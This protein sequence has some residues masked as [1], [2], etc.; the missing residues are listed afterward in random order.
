SCTLPA[1][2]RLSPLSL[3][4]ALPILATGSQLLV[5][6]GDHLG[7]CLVEALEVFSQSLVRV[8]TLRQL[9]DLVPDPV[10]DRVGAVFDLH[11]RLKR[12]LLTVQFLTRRLQ[13]LEGIHETVDIPEGLL[14]FTTEATASR[15]VLQR[16]G[17]LVDI[18]GRPL[19]PVCDRVDTPRNGG[20][21]QSTHNGTTQG[22]HSYRSSIDRTCGSTHS[23]HTAFNQTNHG[24]G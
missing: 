5:P 15:H 23:A 1:T 21:Q 16:L 4:D 6:V 17:Q 12:V 11:L 22:T 10:T 3:H 13:S 2:H 19:G 7:E 18:R 9:V 24:R 20:D 14:Q 8:L